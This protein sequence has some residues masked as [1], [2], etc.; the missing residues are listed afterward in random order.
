[1]RLILP[2]SFHKTFS[3]NWRLNGIIYF[4]FNILTCEVGSCVVYSVFASC[5]FDY[6][7]NDLKSNHCDS[8]F[9]SILT[10]ASKYHYR[11]DRARS[12]TKYR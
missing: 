4:N 3:F 2:P 8:N 5:R 11:A 12:Y 6:N 1:M 7:I 9:S 10:L